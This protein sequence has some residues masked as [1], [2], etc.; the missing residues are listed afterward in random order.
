MLTV[1]HSPTLRVFF[2][3][4]QNRYRRKMGKMLAGRVYLPFYLP[5]Q[6]L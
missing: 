4:N 2:I 1:I 3:A 5:F 6:V